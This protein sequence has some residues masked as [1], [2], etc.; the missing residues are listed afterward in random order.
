[1]TG[2]SEP[3]QKCRISAQTSL[4][5]SGKELFARVAHRLLEGVYGKCLRTVNSFH[6]KCRENMISAEGGR[7]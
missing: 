4:D 7:K 2:E 6:T 3:N 1:M 5:P